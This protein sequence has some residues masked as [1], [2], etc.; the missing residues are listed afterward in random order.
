MTVLLLA[1]AILI[2][3][4]IGYIVGID[5]T[6]TDTMID[7]KEIFRIVESYKVV[8]NQKLSKEDFNLNFTL[9]LIQDEISG[10]ICEQMD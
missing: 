8:S 7:K 2:G 9:Q 4:I 6:L 3:F 10:A 5:T 1:L